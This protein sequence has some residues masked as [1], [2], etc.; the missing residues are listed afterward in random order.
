MRKKYLFLSFSLLLLIISSCSGPRRAIGIEEGWDLLGEDKV[1]FVR[2]K[3]EIIV[4]ARYK[5][6]EIKFKVERREIRLNDLKIFFDNGD[7][8][9]PSMD[10]VIG[11][12][13]FSKSIE[14][15]MEGKYINRIQFVYRTTGT[16]T[17]GRGNVLVFGRRVVTYQQ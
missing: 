11:V 7:K 12:D 9:E 13:Q 1:N 8:L 6:T 5:Y 4:P 3:Q 10:D 17:K 15:G 2:D 16:I 14:L